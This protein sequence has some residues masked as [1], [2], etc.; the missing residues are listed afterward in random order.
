MGK[1]C[2]ELIEKYGSPFSAIFSSV[3]NNVDADME[4]L[5]QAGITHIITLRSGLKMPIKIHYKTPETL[6]NDRIANMCGAWSLFPGKNV[7]VADAGTCIK[8]DL[9][10][11]AGD[12]FGGAI[13]PGLK[14]RYQALSRFTARLPNLKPRTDFPELIGIST[15]GSIRSGVENGMLAEMEGILSQYRNNYPDLSVIVTGG[16]HERFAGKLKSPIFVAPNLT[17]N[18]LKVILDNNDQ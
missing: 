3:N 17:I 7:L 13:S 10:T 14:M 8:Y 16:D 1:A 5:R 15:E 6:G 4:E 9:L 12:Y 11:R 2:S 18:G